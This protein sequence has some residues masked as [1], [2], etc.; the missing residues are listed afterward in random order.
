MV[1]HHGWPVVNGIYAM[2]Y[3]HMVVI[4]MSITNYSITVATVVTVF[5]A[6]SVAISAE[7]VPI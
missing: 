3:F 5:T 2:I 1:D 6:I 7:T 4:V